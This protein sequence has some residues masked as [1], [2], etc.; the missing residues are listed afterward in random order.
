MFG[1]NIEELAVR[2]WWVL[3]G[4][5]VLVLIGAAAVPFVLIRLPADYFVSEKNRGILNN[6]PLPLMY[7][8]LVLKNIFGLVLLLFGI[9]LLFVP[10]Q[11]ILTIIAGLVLMNSP[12][13]RKMMRCVVRRKPVYN[14][15]NWIRAKAGKEKILI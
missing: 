2:Y 15:I 14:G 3:A 1:V 6:L 4:S 11:G 9:I 10:G 12:G 5:V 7:I 8:I 13:K